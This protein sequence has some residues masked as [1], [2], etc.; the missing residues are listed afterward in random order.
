MELGKQEEL[1]RGNECVGI[2]N[3]IDVNHGTGNPTNSA[4][5]VVKTP[6]G[7]IWCA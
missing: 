1:E 5:G 4:K 2:M 6:K 3:R 7:P